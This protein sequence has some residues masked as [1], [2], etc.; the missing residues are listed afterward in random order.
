METL[1]LPRI[2]DRLA[3][4]TSFSASR[5]LAQ[6]LKP[7]MDWEEVQR[8]QAETREARHLLSLGEEISVGPARDIR[9]LVLR[10]A[11]LE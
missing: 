8:R 11:K 4:H 10:A 3:A 1:D 6:E 9:P 5:Q 7:S 2:L